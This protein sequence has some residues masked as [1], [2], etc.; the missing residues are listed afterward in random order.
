MSAQQRSG[1]S[2][3]GMRQL[4]PRPS[5][6]HWRMWLGREKGTWHDRSQALNVAR[7]NGRT[8]L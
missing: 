5:Q 7:Q 3:G 2:A 6:V 1:G 8:D 4:R